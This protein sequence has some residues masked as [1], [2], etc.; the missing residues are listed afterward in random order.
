LLAAFMSTFAAAVNAAPAYLV[1]DIYKRYL[2]DSASEK[3]YVNM[4][5]LCSFLV[6][7]VGSIFGL[8]LDNLNSIIGWIVS[9]L[10]GG[11]TA[12]NLLKWYWWRFN[13]YG[14]FWGM[15]AGIVAA[16]G[17]PGL[18]DVLMENPLNALEAFPINL[19]LSLLG[20]LLG[21]LLTKPD[22]L[23]V[24]KQFYLRTRPW[25]FWRPVAAACR[26]DNAEVTP[27]GAAGRD[28]LNVAVGIVW[29]TA[30]TAAPIFMVIK[31]WTNFFIALAV[32]AVCTVFLKVN[33]YDRM[34]DWPSGV[35][36]NLLDKE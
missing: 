6:V 29:Q 16:L 13:S 5:Y 24:L 9:G 20:C 30:I 34:E 18:L 17:L 1:N 11:Y 33:W 28:L 7:L 27:N 25:G 32:V 12:A 2:N 10:Y 26:A 15:V 3:T 31:S 35:R 4:S 19:G 36:P 21:S 22:P 14:Y 8:F 23:P